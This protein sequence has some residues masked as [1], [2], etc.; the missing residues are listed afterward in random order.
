MTEATAWSGS[1][2]ARKNEN[3]GRVSSVAQVPTFQGQRGEPESMLS[4]LSNAHHLFQ[5]SI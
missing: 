1:K 4:F 3:L 2:T 5:K